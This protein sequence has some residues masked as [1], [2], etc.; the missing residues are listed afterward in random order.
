MADTFD[1]MLASAFLSKSG[2]IPSRNFFIAQGRIIEQGFVEDLKEKY[3]VVKGEEKNT[4]RIEGLILGLLGAVVAFFLQWGV[5]I[6]IAGSIAGGG[7]LS[8]IEIVGFETM[9]LRVL[10]IFAGAG[11][12]IGVGGS[13]LAI[14]KFLQ[15]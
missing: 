15:V 6:L 5:Y 13:L 1:L 9:R 4:A 12:L 2:I 3:V 10:G 11:L 14:R 7:G 8:F